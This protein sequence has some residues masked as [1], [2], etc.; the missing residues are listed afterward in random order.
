MVAAIAATRAPRTRAAVT[1]DDLRPG[2][3]ACVTRLSAEA[4]LSQRLMQL[5][6]LEGTEVQLVRRAPAGD[7]IECRLLG[8]ALSLRRDEAR[9]VHVEVR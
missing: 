8:Y 6:L 5:G 7:P 2:D 9:Q 4:V 3:R 1:L